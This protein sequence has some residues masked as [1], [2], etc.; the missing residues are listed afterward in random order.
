MSADEIRRLQEKALRLAN[1]ADAARHL[2][3]SVRQRI[4]QA[5]HGVH[6]A[7]A[8]PA[9]CDIGVCGD[10]RRFLEGEQ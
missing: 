8:E 9:K 4:H 6:D 2:L 7:S 3:H 10:I 1:T 5:Y